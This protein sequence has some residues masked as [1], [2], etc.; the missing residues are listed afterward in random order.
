[1]Q[2]HQAGVEPSASSIC[3]LQPDVVHW[4]HIYRSNAY[5]RSQQKAKKKKKT[6]ITFIKPKRTKNMQEFELQRL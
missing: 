1:M 4:T 5:E 3:P 2:P 6:N